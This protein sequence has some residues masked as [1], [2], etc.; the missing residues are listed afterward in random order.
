M[1]RHSKFLLVALA[2]AVASPAAAVT[3]ISQS[4]SVSPVATGTSV[5]LSFAQ[6]NPSL[7]MLQSVLLTFTGSYSATGTIRNPAA[8]PAVRTYTLT[9]GVIASIDGAGFDLDVPLGGGSIVLA[10]PAQTTIP[11]SYSGTGSGS[12]LLSSGLGSFIG[13]GSVLLSFIGTSLFNSTG[14]AQLNLARQLGGTV[15]LDYAYLPTAA[16]PEPQTWA[17]MIAGFGLMGLGLR[18]R[19]ATGVTLD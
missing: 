1:V 2:A 11:A 4:I 19:R 9:T 7:G 16:I 14:N 10:I 3:V 5:P 18:R 6:F 15:Q 12:S 8:A 17:L 13:N